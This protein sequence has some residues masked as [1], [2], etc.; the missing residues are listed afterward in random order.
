MMAGKVTE[1]A[2]KRFEE[3]NTDVSKYLAQVKAQVSQDLE[4]NAAIK[5]ID[6]A[7]RVSKIINYYILSKFN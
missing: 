5:G 6:R 1:F 2:K 3:G 4:A 7:Q